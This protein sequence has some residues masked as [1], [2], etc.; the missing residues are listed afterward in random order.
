MSRIL[1]L[2]LSSRAVAL[3]VLLFFLLPFSIISPPPWCPSPASRHHGSALPDCLHAD[4]CG[5]YA[6]HFR[7]RSP[8]RWVLHLSELYRKK[9]SVSVGRKS[10]T[11]PFLGFLFLSGQ[12]FAST[13]VIVG[14]SVVAT[15]IVLQF[16]HHNPNNGQMPRLVRIES[17]TMAHFQA[18]NCSY[19]TVAAR[20]HVLRLF[21]VQCHGEIHIESEEE[22][23]LTHC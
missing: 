13:M 22:V 12:Y 6:C 14:M 23:F 19:F 8:H 3:S 10:N 7:L 9:S 20:I 16:H 4:G 21:T 11:C 15:V 18:V 1:R 5:D 2:Q 17:L